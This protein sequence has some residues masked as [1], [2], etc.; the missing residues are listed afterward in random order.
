MSVAQITQQFLRSS[1]G[2]DKILKIMQYSL[3][4]IIW[5][6]SFKDQKSKNF[7]KGT[8]SLQKTLS[9]GRRLLR[10]GNW[11]ATFSELAEGLNTSNGTIV[12]VMEFA[13]TILG[14]GTF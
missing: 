14:T 2:R 9:E 4:L 5:G 12:G 11:V 1:D 8:T 3:K 10:L 7:E 13:S 6:Y